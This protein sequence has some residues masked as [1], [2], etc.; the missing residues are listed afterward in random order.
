MIELLL[1]RYEIV[2]LT[3]RNDIIAT[4]C[5]VQDTA[6]CHDQPDSSSNLSNGLQI[7]AI[8]SSLHISR[9]LNTCRNVT[10]NSSTSVEMVKSP[11]LDSTI[12]D[13]VRK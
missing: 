6:T 2:E 4:G 7:A 10:S 3:N 8:F 11:L 1:R 13:H 5:T 9:S 12:E